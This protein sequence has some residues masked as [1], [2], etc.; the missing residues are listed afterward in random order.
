MLEIR[1]T[2]IGLEEEELLELEQIIIDRDEKEALIFLKK[3]VYDKIE[4]SQQ[5]RRDHERLGR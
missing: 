1:K 5:V 4:S 3:S 2:A